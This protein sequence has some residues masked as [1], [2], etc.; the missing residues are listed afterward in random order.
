MR[1]FLYIVIIF[2]F[3]SGCKPGIPK[4]IIQPDEMAKVLHD[5][6]IADSYL[7]QLARP[8]S[9]KIIAAGYY[10]SIYKKYDIDSAL[11]AR[12]MNYYYKE[13]QVLNDIYV[14]VTGQLKKERDAIVK[15]DSIFNAN[16][17]LKIKMKTIRD[18]TRTADSTFWA[19]FLL[20]DR[21]K[22]KGAKLTDTAKLK[23]TVK[24]NIDVIR[25]KMDYKVPKI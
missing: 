16:E 14:K 5:I 8:D 11:Y 24:K 20:K 18:S 21:T 17:M 2:F 25:L 22:L 6:H 9:V 23:D 15:A 1:N 7:G 19:D 13:P 3:S 10:K 4:D 12:S